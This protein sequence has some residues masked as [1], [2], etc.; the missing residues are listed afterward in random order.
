MPEREKKARATRL[1]IQSDAA[2]LAYRESFI[3]HPLTMVVETDGRKGVTENYIHVALPEGSTA[4]AG[5]LLPVYLTT[6]E[7]EKT[8]VERI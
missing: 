7:G 2:W 1:K 5:S 3:N 4:E 6:V 8:W